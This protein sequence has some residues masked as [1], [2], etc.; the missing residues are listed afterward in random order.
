MY[1]VAEHQIIVQDQ[2]QCK[3]D[4]ITINEKEYVNAVAFFVTSTTPECNLPSLTLFSSR[5]KCNAQWE[6]L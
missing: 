3:N 1:A 6:N 2:W 5:Q 4:I